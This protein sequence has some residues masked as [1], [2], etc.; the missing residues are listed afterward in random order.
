MNG[1]IIQFLTGVWEWKNGPGLGIG[2]GGGGVRRM[3]EP[4][5]G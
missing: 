5:D 1:K 3:G 4:G 2:C